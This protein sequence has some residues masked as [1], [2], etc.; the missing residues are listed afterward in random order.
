MMRVVSTG[1]AA[2]P[3]VGACSPELNCT[4]TSGLPEKDITTRTNLQYY[5]ESPDATKVCSNCNV[6]IPLKPNAC[7]GC[8]LMKGPVNPK[9]Y[10]RQWVLRAPTPS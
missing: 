3:L 9:G 1:L 4:D 2:L 10:C 7:G 8:K 5:D 6:Y